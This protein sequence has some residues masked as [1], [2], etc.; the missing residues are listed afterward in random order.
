M[1]AAQNYTWIKNNH[2]FGFGW[3]WRDEIQRYLPDEGAI[4]GSAAFN[5]LA[6]A[7]EST[8]SGST[9]APAVVGKTGFDGANF[10]LGTAATY[11]VYLTRGVMKLDQKTYGFYLQDNWRVNGRL[12]LTPGLRWDINPA[13]N[14][15]HHL[16]N[17]FDQKTH[18]LVLPEPLDYYVKNGTTTQQVLDNFKKVNVTFETPE[19]AGLK[20]NNFFPANYMD[21]GPRMGAAYRF[22]D[23]RKAFIL[24]GGYGLYLS[25]L[26]VR[27]VV[28]QFAGQVPFKATYQ[29]NPN[30]SAYSPDGNNSYLLT[31]PSSIVAGVNSS[32]VV[33]TANPNS[34]GIGQ[35]IAALDPTLPTSKVHEWNVEIEKELGRNTVMR[36]K[37][38]GKHGQNLDQQVNLNPQM[39][40]YNWY[41]TTLS[42]FP[43]GAYSN[44]AR[45]TYD[46]NAYTNITYISKTG[47]S[48]SNLFVAEIERRFSKGMQFQAFYTLTNAFRLAGNSFR[49]GV[50]TTPAQFQ[51]GA[52][53]TDFAAMNKFLNYARD[54]GVPN[55][56]V[57]WNWIYDLPFGKGR[58]LLPNAPKWLNAIIGGWTMTG[59][60]TLNSTWFALPSGD[61]GFT[62]EDVH[63]YGTKYPILD[64]TQ[65][66]ASAKTPQD[67]RCYQGYYYW[68]GYISPNRINS[69]NANG[70]PNGIQGIP[71]GIKPAVTPLNPYGTP[72]V[73]TGDWDTNNV[74]INIKNA[75]G[76]I[77]RQQVA[78]DTG[79]NPFRNQYRL[80]PF[81]WIMDS[82][83]RKTFKITERATLRVAFDV[84]NVFN[85]Q[86]LNT[87][88]GNGVVT[89][90]N[91]YNP[92]GFQP[93]QVQGGFRFEY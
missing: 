81:N 83:V 35:A 29:Y 52:V 58:T 80:G 53:P 89:L 90:Q 37:Y 42:P 27:T 20:S 15:E 21:I 34:L 12:T 43:T 56:R 85:N 62:G 38:S 63:V 9:S 55:H 79:L 26:P 8:T 67:V 1:T 7:L 72:G 44:V 61:W 31:H 93:R 22:L 4:S 41:A 60:G 2:T 14:D 70:M 25:G 86:G 48:N 76:T 88:G 59:S 5:S 91:S 13:W 82:S 64:C 11:S 73:A 39:S 19:Q 68:N 47:M 65:T 33:D 36:I 50:G 57:R 84:F 28:T 24:R 92:Y 32:N 66:P 87:P 77:T 49:D 3:T 30:S 16:F 45:R 69:K 40:N 71:D 74:Y 75:N 23:G 17:T 54:T 10:F 18:A 46:T 78:Y 6:T 51:P